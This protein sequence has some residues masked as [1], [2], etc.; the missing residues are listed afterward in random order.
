MDGIEAD[1][2]GAFLAVLETGS[3]TAAGRQLGR[4][5]SV[6]SRRVA[7]LE[8]RIGIRLLERSTRRVSAT[9]AGL[10]FRDRA[11]E[12]MSILRAAHDEARVLSNTP[13]GLLRISLPAGFG[14]KWIAPRLPELLVRYPLLELECN[15]T[16]TFVDLIAGRHDVGV[17]IGELQDS[18]LVAKPLLTMRRLLCASPAYLAAN[19]QLDTPLDLQRHACI[20]FTPLMTHPI[21]HLRHLGKKDAHQRVRIRSR[22]STDDIDT[23]I[24]AALG[25]AGVMLATDWLVGRELRDGRLVRVLPE[26]I[27]AVDERLNIVRASLRHEPAKTRAFI[28]WVAGL[29][30][31]P[32]WDTP[33]PSN[34]GVQAMP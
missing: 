29:F 11:D 24:H 34:A 25:S 6:V 18:R 32:P 3:F 21:W 1:E 16:D 27:G 23:A 31:P 13:S 30:D 22:L 12:A 20:G 4:D 33:A 9:E 17:R 5:G 8:A 10:R 19:P 28:D 7:A 2:I 15:Y 26:W 14:R